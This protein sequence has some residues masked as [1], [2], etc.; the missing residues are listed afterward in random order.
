MK[1]ILPEIVYWCHTE[2]EMS[3]CWWIVI[4]GCTRNCHFDKF[5]CS[6]WQILNQNDDISI[7]VKICNLVVSTWEICSHWGLEWNPLAF[8]ITP[9]W[10]LSMILIPR[11]IVWIKLIKES[12]VMGSLECHYFGK[13]IE[14]NM[15]DHDYVDFPQTFTRDTPQLTCKSKILGD[16]CEL[17]SDNAR[18]VFQKSC[19]VLWLD[20]GL[21]YQVYQC[22]SGLLQWHR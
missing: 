17:K 2:I 4:T 19:Y 15:I 13:I 1:T 16:F 5:H 20:T 14:G 3:S 22:T 18:A 6:Q 11:G 7:S 8:Q 9:L 21:F 12:S 10:P